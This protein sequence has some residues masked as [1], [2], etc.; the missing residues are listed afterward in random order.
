MILRYQVLAEAEQIAVGV[1]DASLAH[2]P[3]SVGRRL[4]ERDIL[5]GDRLRKPV[6]AFKVKVGTAW[7]LCGLESLVDAQMD[8]DALAGEQR[9]A[10]IADGEKPSRL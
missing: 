6:H 3:G 8:L 9:V 5:G 7:V 4:E 1:G 10:V 2:V